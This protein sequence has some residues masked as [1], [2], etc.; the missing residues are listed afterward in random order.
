MV[1]IK[2]LYEFAKDLVRE[3]LKPLNVL[4]KSSDPE[5]SSERMPAEPAIQDTLSVRLQKLAKTIATYRVAALNHQSPSVPKFYTVSVH[6]TMMSQWW[7]TR[8]SSTLSGAKLSLS[9]TPDH[10]KTINDMAN[11]E[12]AK[13]IEQKRT[14]LS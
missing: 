9:L 13:L 5:Q 7:L 1:F 12:E 8:A 2:K 11:L 6:D 3:I 4:F 14:R 10:V